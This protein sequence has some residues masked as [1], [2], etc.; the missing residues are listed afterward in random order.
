MAS[1]NASPS[2]KSRPSSADLGPIR[3]DDTAYPLPVFASLTGLQTTGIRRARRRGLVVRRVGRR[4]YV[5]GADWIA[6][7]RSSAK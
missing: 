5:V 1:V 6:F 7:L 3:G 4:A 2:R